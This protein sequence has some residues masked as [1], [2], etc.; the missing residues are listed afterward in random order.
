MLSHKTITLTSSLLLHYI[1]QLYGKHSHVSPESDYV[2]LLQ[3][4]LKIE[5]D[6][7]GKLKE[8]NQFL[9]YWLRDDDLSN[10]NYYDFVH[11][12]TI[13]KINK[14]RKSFIQSSNHF[15]LKYPHILCNTHELILHCDPDLHDLAS[16]IVVPV[17]IGCSIP[18]VHDMHVYAAFTIAHLKPFSII[19]PLVADDESYE[20][21]Y[22]SYQFS[23]FSKQIMLNWE[24]IHECEDAR[25]AE[26]IRKQNQAF[27]KHPLS[28]NNIIQSSDETEVDIHN[29]YDPSSLKSKKFLN[30]LY[31]LSTANWFN[32]FHTLHDTLNYVSLPVI[33]MSR[34]INWK[35]EIKHQENVIT[36]NRTNHVN[37]LQQ[38]ESYDI[39]VLTYEEL[40]EL[41]SS[42]YETNPSVVLCSFKHDQSHMSPY[43]L[44]QTICITF[45]LNTMQRAAFL[46]IANAWLH[47]LAHYQSSN[48]SNL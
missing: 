17:F 21:S 26:H 48:M 31:S 3:C 32:E 25:D 12:V 15:R 44:C 1:Y 22:S 11:C 27:H 41:Y 46:I 5:T 19:H 33:S 14:A 30:T 47:K 42:T 37:V 13:K 7:N 29:L 18:R 10:L 45:S 6:H 24:A 4:N 8:N 38:T 23:S 34:I 40:S 28:V 39:K 2:P 20:Q 43:V 9:N 16:N 36:S 35:K